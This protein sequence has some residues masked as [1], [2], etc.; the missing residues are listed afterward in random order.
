[1][2]NFK[3]NPVIYTDK[4]EI[5]AVSNFTKAFGNQ[6]KKVFLK[7]ISEGP[8]TVTKEQ[9]EKLIFDQKVNLSEQ[10]IDCAFIMLSRGI[11]QPVFNNQAL[12]SISDAEMS[13]KIVGFNK[14]DISMLFNDDDNNFTP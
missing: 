2:T 4:Q 1:M 12:N 7:A 10:D 13:L 11:P 5:E 3:K 6:Q 9:F 8:E 14:D